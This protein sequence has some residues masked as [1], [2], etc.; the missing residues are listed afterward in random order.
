M[1]V[2]ATL[3]QA[4]QKKTNG[5]R[6]F[7][8]RLRLEGLEGRLLLA[9]DFGDAPLPYPTTLAENGARHE[10]IGPRLG[11]TRDT[12][13]DGAHSASGRRRRRGRR[14]RDVRRDPGGAAR[15]HR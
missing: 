11:A 14:R 5:R 13:A 6:P 2:N 10:A 7:D 3:T 1:K 9:T 12:E 4:R 15:R 8:R